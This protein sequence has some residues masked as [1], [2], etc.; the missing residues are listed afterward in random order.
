VTHFFLSG[1]PTKVT[2][3]DHSVKKAAS[4]TAACRLKMKDTQ[5]EHFWHASDNLPAT[6]IP[7]F[8]FNLLPSPFSLTYT[9]SPH[10]SLS[11]SLSHTLSISL[12]RP[13]DGLFAFLSPSQ[14]QSFPAFL[15][16]VRP[17]QHK[18]AHTHSR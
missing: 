16:S 1:D 4:L 3:L 9:V 17:T 10:L 2:D 14:L 8:L 5:R 15:L 13:A 18:Q 11:G 7:L 12:S 6:R